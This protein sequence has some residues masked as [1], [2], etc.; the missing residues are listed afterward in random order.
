MNGARLAAI[1]VATIAAA[2]T[3]SPASA[4]DAGAGSV[5]AA[6]PAA[7]KKCKKGKVL[8]KSRG[9]KRCIK[10]RVA[11]PRPKEA[12][13]GQLAL[14]LLLSRKWPALRD[15]RGRR[16]PSLARRL[17]GVG[18]GAA[19]ALRET[20][21]KGL[22]L[23]AAQR[24]TNPAATA[25]ARGDQRARAAQDG[26]GS[27]TGVTDG[28]TIGFNGEI[29]AGDITI[30]VEFRA[31][32]A[33]DRIEGE[34]CPT[35]AGRLEG[36]KRGETSVGI[37]LVGPG[38]RLISGYSTTLAEENTYQAQTADDAKLDTLTLDHEGIAKTTIARAGG[39]PLS[40]RMVTRRRAQVNMRSRAYT[41][42]ERRLDVQVRL[43]GVPADVAARLEAEMVRKLQGET[44]KEFA[45][46]VYTGMVKYR[47]MEERFNQDFNRCVAMRFDPRPDQHRYFAGERGRFTAWL[48][49]TLDRGTRPN[50]IF[51]RANQLNVEGS[52]AEATGTTPAFEF[53]VTTAANPS[54]VQYRATSKAGVAFGTHDVLTQS[55][56][57]YK[58]VGM[59]YTDHLSANNIYSYLGCTYSSSQNNTT[60]FKDSGE[61]IDGAVARD[62]DGRLG[63]MLK[64]EGTIGKYAEFHGCKWN[65]TAS[66]RVQCTLTG[67]GTEPFFLF[68]DIDIPAGDGPARVTWRPRSPDIGDVPPT[69]SPCEPFP[70]TG[71]ALDPV[72][73]HVP[74]NLFF[75]AGTHS[76]AVDVPATVPGAGG[77]GTIIST[78]HYELTFRRVNEDGSPYTG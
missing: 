19:P 78:A 40:L 10:L 56:P 36:R 18:H 46:V 43:T 42:G 5:G 35:G 6:K 13:R 62:L 72:T 49:P 55:N 16:V 61:P 51:K 30:F 64:A 77:I 23:V 29:P 48:E 31:G 70:L 28:T 41:A 54:W 7:K 53:L 25:A 14:D 71:P 15:R 67:T 50:G 37:R 59:A 39:A 76:I 17:R 21:A 68:V 34:D 22:A 12:D 66:A 9:K 44:D 3:V 47:Q 75:D 63:G 8:V 1:L 27:V 32:L 26:G 57:F 20:Y 74:R 24:Q 69:I 73:T 52:P 60:T 2:T 4:A 38:G 58:A 33:S 45:E 65:D 11:P